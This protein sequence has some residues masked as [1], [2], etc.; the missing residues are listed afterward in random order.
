MT[1]DVDVALLYP[2]KYLKAEDLKGQKVT[3]TV[4]GVSQDNLQM[5]GGRK[6]QAVV[7]SMKGKEKQFVANT[8]NGWALAL[9]LGRRTK[10]WV[11]KRIQL[12][13]DVDKLRGKQVPCVRVA[14]SPDAPPDRAA[15]FAR[16]W[17]GERMGGEFVGRLKQEVASMSP[18]IAQPVERAEPDPTDSAD[19]TVPAPAE[20]FVGGDGEQA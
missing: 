15:A 20:D 3:V 5:P 12:A 4:S 6:K 11:G 2:S 16:A 13:P 7:I 8:T 1:L 10:D 14:G 9:L 19:G 18:M 17:K